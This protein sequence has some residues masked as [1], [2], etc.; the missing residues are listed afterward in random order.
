M[1]RRLSNSR[2]GEPLR[3]H[4]L[5]KRLDKLIFIE[6]RRVLARHADV[7]LALDLVG[8]DG[9]VDVVDLGVRVPV[10]EAEVECVESDT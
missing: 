9:D 3:V 2:H 1:P 5:G 10:E 4:G 8:G 6:N 7:R